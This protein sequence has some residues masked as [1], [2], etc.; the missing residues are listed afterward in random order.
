MTVQPVV[1]E[2]LEHGGW[3]VRFLPPLADW[4]TDDPLGRYLAHEPVDR[5]PRCGVARRST[6]GCTSDSRRGRRACLRCTDASAQAAIILRRMRLRF[7]KMQGAGN[8]FVVLDATRVPIGVVG[9]AGAAAERPPLRHRCRPGAG[10]R[11]GRHARRRLPLPHLQRLQRRRGRALR[12]R[13]ALLRALRARARPDRQDDAAHRDHQQPARAATAGRRPRDGGHEPADV[14]A[15]R[16]CRSTP[17]AWRR[18]KSTDS[19]CGRST[20]P[21]G[22]SRSRRCRWATRTPCCAWTM[23]TRRRSPN[24]GRP[25]RATP[26]S[27]AVSTPASCRSLSRSEVALRV[28]ERGAGETL[29]CGTGACA[30]V[31]AGIR[32]G[33]LGAQVDVR[34]P[35]RIAAHRMAGGGPAGADDRPGRNRF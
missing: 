23:S 28:Y 27:R 2:M 25:S 31:V 18:A 17:A 26:A 14:R 4:P 22:T 30:A 35:W 32:L 34:H 9:G 1:A 15:S 6:C 29:A 10:G 8:D 21:A 7:T 19:R 3:R 5:K 20:L 13:R 12:Q 24:W 16:R 33:W 11:E